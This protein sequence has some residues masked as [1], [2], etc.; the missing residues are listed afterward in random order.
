MDNLPGGRSKRGAFNGPQN[1]DAAC[2]ETHAQH[3]DN[4][5]KGGFH[6]SLAIRFCLEHHRQGHR[7]AMTNLFDMNFLAPIMERASLLGH[8]VR[9]KRVSVCLCMQ[10][11]HQAFQCLRTTRRQ[12]W[13]KREG[14]TKQQLQNNLQS[15][16]CSRDP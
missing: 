14:T 1:E 16:E 9:H 4:V 2:R 8:T 12:I 5:L 6:H 10:C 7:K 11:S 3:R 13:R 15:R